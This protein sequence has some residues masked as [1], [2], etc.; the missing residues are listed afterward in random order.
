MMSVAV[1]YRCPECGAT[2]VRP[3]YTEGEPERRYEGTCYAPHPSRNAG[4]EGCGEEV[5]LVAVAWRKHE[6]SL[7]INLDE[8]GVRPDV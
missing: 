1:R 3:R 6:D 4:F 5:N 8:K 2:H 7:W